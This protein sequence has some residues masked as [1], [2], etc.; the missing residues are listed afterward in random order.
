MPPA[1]RITDLHVCPL[2]N[3]LV[4][5]VGGPVAAGMPT[6]L[7]GMMPAARVGDVCTCVGPPDAI[8]KGSPTVLIGGMMAARMGDLTLH[9]G[10]IVLGFPTVLIGDMGMGGA[11][12]ASAGAGSA[13]VAGG[14]GAAG[15]GGGPGGGGSGPPHDITVIQRGKFTITVDRT[16][17]TIT[18]EGKEEFFGDGATQK[19]V[20]DAI[21]SINRTWSGTT[22]FEGSQYTVTSKVTGSMRGVNDPPDPN[23]NQMLVKHTTDPPNVHKNND[24]ANQPYYGRS[25]GMIHD[26]ED[27]GGTLSIPHEMGHAMGLKDEYTEGPP[28]ANGNRTLVRTGPPGGLM[29]YIDPGSKPTPQN[30]S[31]LITGNNLAP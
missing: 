6:V 25:P 27:D 21:A 26:N 3:G 4:P 20:D 12:S 30:Y 2:V 14:S 10:N 9:G 7:I 28:D 29:G 31:D 16:A 5:H 1:A 19:V 17:K 24:P 13:A 23:A 15:A 22:T 11:G 8:A 18:I